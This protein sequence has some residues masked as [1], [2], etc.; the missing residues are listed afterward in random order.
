[1]YHFRLLCIDAFLG[2]VV[3]DI[4]WQHVVDLYH[5]N[6]GT[7]AG[8]SM[9]HKLKYEHIHLTSFSKMRVDLAAQVFSIFYS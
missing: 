6:A 4:S 3:V 7:G 1:M 8:L 9:V 5:R 2:S